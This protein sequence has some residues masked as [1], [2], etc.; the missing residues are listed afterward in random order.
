M[1]EGTVWA[2]LVVF[3]GECVELGGLFGE[4]VGGWLLGVRAF[5][6]LVEALILSLGLWVS[7]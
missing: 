2:F 6:C 4:R 1:A 7:G 5:L 3:V